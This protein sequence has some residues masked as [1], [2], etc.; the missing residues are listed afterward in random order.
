MAKVMFQIE[1][2]MVWKVKNN[3]PQ[4]F[5][6]FRLSGGLLLQLHRIGDHGEDE[7]GLRPPPIRSE[8]NSV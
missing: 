5:D 7:P 8:R 2:K 1:Q 3:E 4:L 6:I